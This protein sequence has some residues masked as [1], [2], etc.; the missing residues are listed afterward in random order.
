[1]SNR[2]YIFWSLQHLRYV[3]SSF[4]LL[5]LHLNVIAEVLG[6]AVGTERASEAEF[7]VSDI[8]WLE[9]NPIASTA[10]ETSYVL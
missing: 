4:Y 2:I 1:M 9:D 6:K 3:T 10:G 5:L 8:E 7:M